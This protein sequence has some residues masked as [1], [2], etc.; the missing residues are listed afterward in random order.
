MYYSYHL[1]LNL[2][3][4]QNSKKNVR[5][6][7]LNMKAFFFFFRILRTLA[8]MLSSTENLSP[9]RSQEC[10]QRLQHQQK[11]LSWPPCAASFPASHPDSQ[12]GRQSQFPSSGVVVPHH[13]PKPLGQVI[14][15]QTLCQ[16]L[17]GDEITMMKRPVVSLGELRGG[18]EV[19]LYTQPQLRPLI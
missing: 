14:H 4:F 3:L 19:I 6:S 13:L 11:N 8:C 7:F 10:S 15:T 5:N 16:K 18:E 1:V 17:F 2:K 12:R 9:L